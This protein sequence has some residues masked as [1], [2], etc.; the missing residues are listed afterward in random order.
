[1]NY[2]QPE[3]L[4]CLAREYALGTLQGRAR[5]R[6]ERVLNESPAAAQAVGTWQRRLDVLADGVAALPPREAV[7]RGL[8]SRLFS[9]A[10]RAAP[11]AG[12]WWQLLGQMLS[13][14]TLGGALAGAM[15]CVVLLQWQP[16]LV[17]LEPQRDS[18]PES[19]VGLLL[20]DAGTATLLASSRRQGRQLT[21]KLLQPLRV[22][23]GQVAQL[24]ALPKDGSAPFPFGTV[25]CQGSATLTLSDSS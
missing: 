13:G 21:V 19:Y 25:P 23:A 11:A 9:D 16:G 2:L 1:M 8:Q 4:D 22:P 3:R 24:W 10:D 14:R 20:D 18:L 5:R 7:W 6:F 17:G 15:L 12:G